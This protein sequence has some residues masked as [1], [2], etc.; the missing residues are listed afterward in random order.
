MLAHNPEFTREGSAVADFL[1]PD[2]VV[3]GVER[4]TAGAQLTDALRQL[5]AP[6]DAPIVVTDLATAETI[7]VGSNVFL[8]SKIAFANELARL[9][10][11]VG[12]DVEQVVDAIG[13]DRR[14]GRAFFSPGPGFGGACLPSQSRELPRV[15]A[16]LGMRTPLID[17]I[18]ASNEEMAAWHVERIRRALG[19]S[20]EGVR[21]AL[22]GLT[23]KAGTDDV[24]ESPALLIAQLL[25]ASGGQ[26]TV[27]DPSGTDAALTELGRSGV[28]A[29][30]AAGAVDACAGADAVVVCTEW[31]LFRELDWATIAAGMRGRLV[32]D[33]RNVID[34]VAAA[35]AG[36]EVI[37][38][39][40]P[41][42]GAA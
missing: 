31:P 26:L 23:F 14:I 6:L 11:S 34:A 12:A 1:A 15:A 29:E 4:P 24:R 10:A 9:S 37:V 33:T 38:L 7:K 28:T 5:Y 39:G 36:C 25:A 18:A 20:L 17:G 40:R 2:R 27:F 32:V 35:A 8:A 19:G 30:A 22:L 3:V 16:R 42:A 13:L 41:A 21:V